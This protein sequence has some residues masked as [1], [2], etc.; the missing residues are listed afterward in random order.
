MPAMNEMKRSTEF[1]GEVAIV[2]GASSGIG[3]ACA[4][5]LAE[6]G[7]RVVVFARSTERIRELAEKWPNQMVAVTGDASDEDSLRNL[8]TSTE[9]K[10]G[11]CTV[12]VN[13]AGHIEPKRVEEMTV[14]EWDLHF[15][16]NVRAAFITS[17]L[18]LSGMRRA[19]RG[20]IV[21]IAS[22]SGIPG[23]QKFPGFTAYCA[24]KGALISF[25]EALAVELKGTGVRVNCVSPGSV[26]TPM[27][28]RVAPTLEAEISPE[29]MAE[30]VA[31]LASPRSGAMNGQNLHGF[32][33]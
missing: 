16:V 9:E 26:D 30:L 1:A 22:I 18:A 3:R 14:E 27:L 2:T 20:S 17:R 21:N 6:S 33:A 28:R 11:P 13:N 15:S 4:V 32:G 24:S 8:I 23:P 19:G 25:T 29:E 10:F 7:A 31:F 5:R 12:L